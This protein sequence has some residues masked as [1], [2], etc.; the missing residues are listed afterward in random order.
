MW[1]RK[2][3]REHGR[4]KGLSNGEREDEKSRIKQLKRLKECINVTESKCILNKVSYNSGLCKVV[5]Y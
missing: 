2:R 1:M 4:E 5:A 3:E